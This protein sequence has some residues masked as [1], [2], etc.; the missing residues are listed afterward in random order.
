MNEDL[1][2]AEVT[3][4]SSEA[5]EKA[6]GKPWAAWMTLLDDAGGRQMTHK[7]LVAHLAEHYNIS[8]WW[9]Q[10]VTVAYE[11]SRRLREKHEMPDG[12]Q[13]S[14]SRTMAVAAE[15]IYDAWL[16]EATRH[17]WLPDAEF[18]VRKATPHKILRLNWSDGTWVEVRFDA[19]GPA[20]CTVTVQQDKLPDSEAAEAMKAY[21]TAALSRLQE[22]VEG[23]TG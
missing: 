1:D 17:F 12:Y 8:P 21:W 7:Q 9:Q 11:Q 20:R 23:E 22:A 3:N 15:R 13:I 6:T 2:P 16:N 5:V 10:Q 19:K 4:T 18:T 14:R